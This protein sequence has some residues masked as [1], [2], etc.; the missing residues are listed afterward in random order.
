MYVFVCKYLEEKRNSFDLSYESE[1]IQSPLK[2]LVWNYCLHIKEEHK[3][4]KS[5]NMG[6][7]YVITFMNF[8][9]PI[10]SRA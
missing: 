4:R 3:C 9:K 1:I 10:R 7:N 2:M 6:I 8:I 5:V